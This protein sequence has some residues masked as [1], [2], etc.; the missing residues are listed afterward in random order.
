MQLKY[1]LLLFQYS[2]QYRFVHVR[3]PKVL[4]V[5]MI[6][7]FKW[8]L[9]LQQKNVVETIVWIFFLEYRWIRGTLEN[10]ASKSEVSSAR[11]HGATSCSSFGLWNMILSELSWFETCINFLLAEKKM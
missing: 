1:Q 6:L 5:V 8:F 10:K 3:L 9:R 2:K 7:Y 4:V 11:T